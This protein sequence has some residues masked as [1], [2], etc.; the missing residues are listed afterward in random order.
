ML[1]KGLPRLSDD[2]WVCSK[3][4]VLCSQQINK[5]YYSGLNSVVPTETKLGE[6]YTFTTL[7]L[8]CCLEMMEK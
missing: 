3:L 8:F 6:T 4:V 1:Q 7:M 2:A 5:R